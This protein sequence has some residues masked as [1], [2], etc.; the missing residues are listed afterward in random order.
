MEKP[1]ALELGLEKEFQLKK[2][3][4]EVQQMSLEQA[5]TFLMQ[6]YHHMLVKDAFYQEMLKK[7]WGIGNEH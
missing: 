6:V 5:R 3:E 7:Q 1:Q 2:F 4:S